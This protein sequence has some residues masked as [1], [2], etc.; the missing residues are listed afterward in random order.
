MTQPRPGR[1]TRRAHVRVSILVGCALLAGCGPWQFHRPFSPPPVQK[2]TMIQTRVPRPGELPGVIGRL[3]RHRVA[4]RE[5]LLDV[6]RDAGLGFAEVRD[7]N[8]GI[9]EW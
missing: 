1:A 3:Q 5:T 9:N 6:A 2:L 8:P 7:A 4:P